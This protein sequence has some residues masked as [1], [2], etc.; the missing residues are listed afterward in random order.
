MASER[1]VTQS[2]EVTNKFQCPNYTQIPNIIFDYWISILKPTEF[3]VLSFLCRHTFGFHYSNCEVSKSML[4]K[5]LKMGKSTVNSAVDALEKHGIILK[6]Q[7]KNQNGYQPNVYSL[8]IEIP[9]YELDQEEIK[10]ILPSPKSGLP[11][12]KSLHTPLR[13]LTPPSPNSDTRVVQETNHPIYKDIKKLK[14]E[15]SPGRAETNISSSNQPKKEKPFDI[16]SDAYRLAVKFESTIKTIIPDFKAKSLTTWAKQIG[17]MIH[18]DKRSIAEIEAV[19]EWLP[20]DTFNSDKVLCPEKLRK[21]FV[22]LR[23]QMQ[24]SSVGKTTENDAEKNRKYAINAEKALVSIN[25]RIDIL[26]SCVEVVPLRGSTLPDVLKF[27]ELG[28]KEQFDN[29]LRKREFKR[30]TKS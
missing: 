11:Y 1:K 19:I 12:P 28:F 21:R 22:E 9:K 7:H 24:K 20:T 17:F 26:G 8:N 23:S 5:M 25:F 15:N 6:Y 13:N 18:I 3:V 10:E 29:I 4:G 30:R 14:K 2:Q 16:E 27:S